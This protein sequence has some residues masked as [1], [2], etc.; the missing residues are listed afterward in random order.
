MLLPPLFCLYGLIFSMTIL[1]QI[2]AGF[3]AM[4]GVEIAAVVTSFLCVYLTVKNNIWNWFWG[5]WGV[6]LYGIVFWQYRNYANFGLQVFYFLPIQFI[7]WWVWLR[8][9]PKKHDDLP[10][11]VLSPS[12]RLLWIG[13]MA[14]LTGGL[15]ALLRYGL[16]AW[17]PAWAPDPLPFADGL[18]T[19]GSIVAQ[20]LQVYKRWENWALW[21]AV[22]VVYAFY[23][24]PMQKLWASALLYM[25]FTVLAFIGARDWTKL[26]KTQA[27]TR[28]VVA[29]AG[30]A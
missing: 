13:V 10:V 26:L 25:V 6:V 1:Q 17:A 24:F 30:G 4:S 2:V 20:Y 27:A 19:A 15:Y 23:V 14:V 29:E 16:P 5:F 21:I 12:A 18:T 22:D 8:G 9:G 7:G 3:R 11:T 28:A